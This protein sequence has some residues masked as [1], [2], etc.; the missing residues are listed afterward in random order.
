VKLFWSSR[1]PFARKVMIAAHE[2]G[3]ADHIEIV[4]V[5][6]HPADPN[7]EVMR[8]NPLGKIPTLVLDDGTVLH[9]SVVI[10]EYLDATFGGTL[11]PAAGAPRWR[12]LTLQALADGMMEA[13][14]RWLEERRLPEPEWR[15]AMI[16]GMQVKLEA[17]LDSLDAAPPSTIT[18][19]AIALASALA[20]LDFRFA[21]APWRTGR[22]RLA[23]WFET[24]AA[25]PSMTATAFADQY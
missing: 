5:V 18:V 2:L 15:R 17:A 7:R 1:S 21:D 19:G 20:H 11:L 8:V 25:R 9:D 10:M 12:A 4:R 3:V 23:A 13:D 14:L 6:A 22:P 24:F 16:A